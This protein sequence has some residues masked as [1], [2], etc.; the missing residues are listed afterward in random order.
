MICIMVYMYTHVYIHM[1]KYKNNDKKSYWGIDRGF[2]GWHSRSCELEVKKI[3]AQ[4]PGPWLRLRVSIQSWGYPNSW[5]VYFMENSE[6]I[7]G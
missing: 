6:V 5:K 1:Y 4:Q 7:A 2:L 3:N